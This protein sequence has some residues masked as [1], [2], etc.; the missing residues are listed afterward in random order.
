MTAALET[1]T[2]TPRLSVSD[3]SKTYP[4]TQALAGVSV[5]VLP[6]EIHGI[7]GQNGAGKST[8]VRILSGIEEPDGGI[9]CIDGAPPPPAPPRAPPRA[10]IFP[11]HQEPGLVRSLS[12]AENI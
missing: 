3:V 6:G 11:V 10:Q 2:G 5:E 12:V 7:A 1:R 9:V 4:G 8:L